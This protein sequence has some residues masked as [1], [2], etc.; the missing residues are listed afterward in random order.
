[1]PLCSLGVQAFASIQFHTQSVS[2]FPQSPDTHPRLLPSVPT[3]R[4]P[5][6]PNPGLWPPTPPAPW[7]LPTSRTRTATSW[8]QG[9]PGERAG[10]RSGE[11]APGGQNPR[12]PFQLCRIVHCANCFNLEGSQIVATARI[13]VILLKSQTTQLDSR[14]TTKLKKSFRSNYK[15]SPILW[16][17]PPN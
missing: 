3:G 5:H 10:G 2:P 17:F 1:M 16:I 4:P 15:S 11:R 6:S 13:Y 7:T 14:T 12:A 9:G 8:S